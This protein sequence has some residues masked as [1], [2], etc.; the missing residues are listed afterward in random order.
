MNS[1]I[2][3]QTFDCAQEQAGFVACQLSSRRVRS[4]ITDVRE[5][6]ELAQCPS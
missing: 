5:I 6:V 1:E 4:L 3:G 2:E